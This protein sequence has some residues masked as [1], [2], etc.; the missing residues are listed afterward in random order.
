MALQH[1]ASGDVIKVQ[2]GMDLSHFS[3]IAL[4]K[5]DEQE[6]IRMV[7]PKDKRVP[8]HHVPGEVT[9]LCLRGEVAVEAGGRS[10]VLQA[11]QMMYLNGGVGH[12]LHALQDSLLLRTIL[13]VG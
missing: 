13:L 3:S 9:M 1:A 7:L 5:T 10:Q 2:D 6:L 4:A 11:G 8:E 12:A